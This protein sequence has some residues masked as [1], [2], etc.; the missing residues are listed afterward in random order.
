MGE[1]RVGDV[2]VLNSGGPDMVVE[3]IEGNGI[4][5]FTWIGSDG[6]ER[7][8]LLPL[9]CVTLKTGIR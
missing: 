3:A 9:A 6:N 5:R 8:I 1:I 2:V 7:N 4:G